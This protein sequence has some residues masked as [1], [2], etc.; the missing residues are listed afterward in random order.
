M[1]AAFKK[2]KYRN[3]SEREF[4]D[5]IGHCGCRNP[6]CWICFLVDGVPRRFMKIVD[7]FRDERPAYKFHTD[8]IKHVTLD[9]G[10][11]HLF[12]CRGN[13]LPPLLWDRTKSCIQELTRMENL[14]MWLVNIDP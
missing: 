11:L 4:V 3:M 7:P 2:P 1:K 9:H 13:I 14:D 12:T 8:T 6:N 5:S 10:T